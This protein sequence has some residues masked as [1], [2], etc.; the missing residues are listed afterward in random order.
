MACG[1]EITIA[2][3]EQ[4]S[5]VSGYPVH[6]T[7]NQPWKNIT[8]EGQD[9]QSLI[10][11]GVVISDSAIDQICA[12][13]TKRISREKRWQFSLSP[14]GEE[15]TIVDVIRRPEGNM[16]AIVQWVF[17]R[18]CLTEHGGCGQ[19][20][21]EARGVMELDAEDATSVVE[22]INNMIQIV[23]AGVR[24]TIEYRRA[25]REAGLDGAS[26]EAERRA[27]LTAAGLDHDT[28]NRRVCAFKERWD[29]LHGVGRK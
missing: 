15:P 5:V 17:N 11:R 14:A 18:V 13:A 28:V 3:K 21:R 22:E 2:S 19:S 25:L 12:E 23:T 4:R 29:Q 10:E 20:W 27:C 9:A 1:K 16:M 8:P 7:G 26:I 6:D 24:D